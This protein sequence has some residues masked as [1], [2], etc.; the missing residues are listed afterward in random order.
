[1]LPR[2]PAYDSNNWFGLFFV[3][4]LVICMY[5]FLSILLAVV[6]TKYKKHLQVKH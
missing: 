6:Y 2:I 1:M 5:I 4:F 3:A